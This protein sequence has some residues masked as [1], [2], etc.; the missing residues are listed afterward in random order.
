MEKFQTYV[1]E[2]D[3][4]FEEATSNFLDSN[5]IREKQTKWKSWVASYK[6]SNEKNIEGKNYVMYI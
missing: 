6:S 1:A 5:L 4:I 3:E 2:I